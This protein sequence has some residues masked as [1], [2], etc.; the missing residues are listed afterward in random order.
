MKYLKNIENSPLSSNI[1]EKASQSLIEG[2]TLSL[3]M[4]SIM[5]P[6]VQKSRHRKQRILVN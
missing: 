5:M 3:K 2:L 6:K 1:V 4:G